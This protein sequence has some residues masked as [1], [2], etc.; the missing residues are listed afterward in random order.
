M[1]GI[2]PLFRNLNEWWSVIRKESRLWP[3]FHGV[4]LGLAFNSL[5]TIPIIFRV[6]L[7]LGVYFAASVILAVIFVISVLKSEKGLRIRKARLF[8][9]GISLISFVFA[10]TDLMQFVFGFHGIRI[11][12]DYPYLWL[13]DIPFVSFLAS[14]S[15]G[16][17][18][19]MIERF[20]ELHEKKDL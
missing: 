5:F 4:L 15:I 11:S 2:Y 8:F 14:F 17:F 7:Y 19:G 12:F 20:L 13:G 3:V 6:N 10:L 18:F 9:F 1:K 16:G